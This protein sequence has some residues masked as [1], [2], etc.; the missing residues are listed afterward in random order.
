[1]NKTDVIF[2]SFILLFSVV[3]YA[4]ADFVEVLPAERLTDQAKLAIQASPDWLQAD[5]T[6]NLERMQES[7]QDIYAA[8]IL[9]PSETRFRDEIAF[10]VANI[11][12]A[13]LENPNFIPDLLE[14]NAAYIY[15]HDQY[16]DYVRVSDVG[17]PDA[18]P[19]YYTTTFYNIKESE[20]IVEYELPKEI[21]Y[22]NIVHP[23]IEDESVFYI[24]PYT[25]GDVPAAPPT[26]VFWRDWIFTITEVPG[27]DDT[28]PVLRDALSGIDTLWGDTTTGAIG[29]LSA[30]ERT[31]MEFSSG[32]ERPHQ[33]VR[34]YAKHLGRC[35]EWQDLTS[36]ASRACLIPCLNT[37][38]IGEDHVWN[39]FWH[40]RWIHWEPVNGDDYIDNPLVYENRWG[41]VFS[42]VF[43]VAGDGYIW[44][45]IDRYSEGHCSIN[46]T[47]LDANGDPVDGARLAV[48]NNGYASCYSYVGSDGETSVLYGDAISAKGKIK[49]EIGKYP[50]G[51]AT[52]NIASETVDGE[53]YSWVAQY[54]TETIPQILWKPV[55][56]S[57]IT[58]YRLS[59]QY[60]VTG[61]VKTGYYPFDKQNQYTRQTNGGSIDAFIVDS[62]N[63]SLYNGGSEFEA[64]SIQK[65]TSDASFQFILPAFDTWTVILSTERKLTSEEM[66]SAVITL[67]E[68]QNGDWTELVSTTRDLSLMPG[69]R[70]MASVT[71]G[72]SLGVKVEM[73]SKMMHP[74][75][76]CWCN[77]IVYNPNLQEPGMN[78]PL[79]VILDVY[80]ELFFAP[81][82]SDFSNYT[83][84]NLQT[85][86]K[87]V[88]SVLPEFTWPDISGVTNGILWYAAMTNPEMTELL[89]EMDIFD[90]GWSE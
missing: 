33:P 80:G 44:D 6:D 32:S 41:K 52:Y 11:G 63:L 20:T 34:I 46:V 19:G 54:D 48:K 17:D 75:D 65:M 66:V 78:I 28:Y 16:L 62:A 10:C 58:N 50:S 86:E 57:E 82:F 83:V 38:A 70:Y 77:T 90:F 74:G 53:T 60:D 18:D 15:E 67:E 4:T 8:M 40:L 69:E 76:L 24:D 37:E 51:G 25:E 2:I 73:S 47:V 7:F 84:E 49:S 1:M 23:K 72:G 29:A 71:A 55:T 56:A 45:V 30:W 61:E 42:G 85:A 5:L 88:F 64:Y 35:G 79:F 22:W 31:V 12:T 59:V 21:Y 9:H 26:G 89:G 68:N 3:V 81:E 87:Q 13:N 36:A 27:T 43:N 39:E 14:E